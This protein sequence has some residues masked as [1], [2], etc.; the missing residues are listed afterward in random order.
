MPTDMISTAAIHQDITRLQHEREQLAARQ[1]RIDIELDVLRGILS[2]AGNLPKTN[3]LTLKFGP[4]EAVRRALRDAG[5]EAPRA[6]VKQQA[7]AI[8]STEPEKA[9][10]TIDQTIRNMLVLSGELNERDGILSFA[11]ANTNGHQ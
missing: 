1:Q 3:V 8:V 10:K 9:K 11:T 7:L 6:L 4:S 5:G 2:R